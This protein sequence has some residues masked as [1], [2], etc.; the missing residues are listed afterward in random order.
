MSGRD[1]LLSLARAQGERD[2]DRILGGPFFRDAGWKPLGGTENNYAIVSNQQSSPVNSLCEK[3]VNSIDHVLIKHCLMAG[4]RPAGRGAPSSMAEAL[5]RYMGVPGG[6]ISKLD[7]PKMLKL[8]QNVRVMADGAKT[9]SP[10]IVVADRGEGQEPEK[11]E[12]TLLSLQKGNKKRIKFV[13]GKYN[14]GGTGVL[15]FCGERGYQLIAARRSAE[16]APGSEWGFTLVRETPN[17]SDDDKTTWYE[18]FVGPDGRICTVPGGPLEILPGGGRLEDGCMVKMFDYDIPKRSIAKKLWSDMNSVLYSPPLPITVEDARHPGSA[19]NPRVMYGSRNL[20]EREFRPHVYRSFSIRSKLRG[21]GTNRIDVAV[22]RHASLHPDKKNVARELRPKSAAILLTQNGQT[23]ASFRQSRLDSESGL[24]SLAEYAMVHVD[25]TDL[26]PRKAKMFLASRD[27][28]RQSADSKRLE[29]R[30]LEDVGEDEQVRALE[31][32][33]RKLDERI[34]VKDSSMNRAIRDAVSRNKTISEMLSPGSTSAESGKPWEGD[35]GDSGREGADAKPA[36]YMPTYLRFKNGKVSAHRPVPAD[37]SAAYVTLETDAPDDYT[38]RERD[39]GSLEAKFP[40][41]LDGSPHGP[42]GGR[43]KV[44][45]RGTGRPSEDAGDVVVTLTRPGDGPLSCVIHAIFVEPEERKKR[46]G[47]RLQS[48]RWVTRENW[49]EMGWGA[50]N[51]ARASKS[52]VLVNRNCEFLEKFQKTR[53]RAQHDEIAEQFGLHVF[54][55]SVGLYANHR[56]DADYDGIYEKSIEAVARSC[57]PA[58]YGS[59]RARRPG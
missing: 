33:Y 24:S 53:P 57:L 21:F 39:A 43:V 47:V 23:H 27:R 4:D 35:G 22:L 55:A 32:E 9:S 51:V 42:F 19:Q 1:A 38:T 2:V 40:P 14:M 34:S 18:Y 26:P 46:S 48:F 8:A 36:S 20:L 58:S 17:A 11:F 52:E 31:S 12:T 30:I 29:E 28:M 3:P 41:A 6:D 5:E 25:L 7:G 44:K 15:P 45:V 10:N 16:L 56:D 37:G 50:K 54:F 13:Q 59:A 49:A